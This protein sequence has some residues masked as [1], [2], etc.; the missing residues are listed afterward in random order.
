[1]RKLL[2]SFIALFVMQSAMAQFIYKIKADSVLITNDSCTAELNLENSTKNVPGSFLY[3]KGKGRTEFRKVMTKINDSIYLIGND[4]LKTG[5]GSSNLSFLDGLIRSGNAVYLGNTISGSGTHNFTTNRYQYLNGNFYSIGGTKYDPVTRPVFRFYDNGDFTSKAQNNLTG[6]TFTSESNG[7]RYTAKYGIFEVGTANNFDTSISTVCCGSLSKSAIV[8]NSDFLNTF[9]GDIHGS[10]IGG[11]AMNLQ[12]VAWSSVFGE[13]HGA[14]GSGFIN[15]SIIGGYGHNFTEE[16][17]GSVLGG[18]A[19]QIVKPMSDMI[20]GG[21]VNTAADTSNFS[22]IGGIVNQ[23]GGSGQLVSGSRLINKTP[24]GTTVG[25]SN[26]DFISLPYTGRL[27]YT[28][29]TLTGIPNLDKY[30]IFAI[31]N[32][33]NYNSPTTRSNAMT[34]LYNGRTQ[35]NTTGFSNTLT[36]TDVTPKAAFE[37]VSTNSGVLLPKLTTVQRDAIITADKQNGLLLYNTDNSKFQFYNGSAWKTICDSCTTG[38]GSGTAWSLTGNAGISY[39]ANFLGTTDNTTLGFRA[40]NI[41]RGSLSAAGNWTFSSPDISGSGFLVNNAY[42]SFVSSRP[43]NANNGPTVTIQSDVE[44]EAYGQLMLAGTSGNSAVK[45]FKLGVN[46]TGSYGFLNLID[47]NSGLG[48]PLVLQNHGGN[49]GIGTGVSV[50]PAYKLD[51]AGTAR[52]QTLPFIASRDTVVT[53]DPVTKQ[54]A[55]TKITA[56]G[57]GSAWL[58]TG[59]AGTVA[60]TNFVGTTDNIDLRFRTNNTEKVTITSGGIVGIGIMTPA[61]GGGVKLHVPGNITS[62]GL[63]SGSEKFGFGAVADSIYATAIGNSSNAKFQATAVGSN[64]LATGNY[65]VAIGREATASGGFDV[66]LGRAA[67][68]SGIYSTAIGYSSAVTHQGSIVIGA[69]TSS[70]T[71]NQFI[72]GS[73]IPG[74]D[75]REVIFGMGDASPNAITYGGV[76][77]RATNGSGTDNIGANLRIAAGRGTGAGVGGIISFFTTPSG[78]AGTTLNTENEVM[79]LNQ[80]GNV[81]IGTTNPVYRLDVNG[82]ARIQTLPFIAS[83]DTVVTY[84]PVSKQLAVTKITAGGG[85]TTVK[86]TAD[87]TAQTTTT[88]ADATGLSFAAA[89]NTYYHFKFVVVFRTAATTTGIQLSVAAP[90]TPT[91]FSAKASIA[92]A[93]DGASG[94]WQGWITASND[95]VIG[96]GVQAANTDYV[97]IV[98]GTIR[99]GATAGTVQLRYASEVA[100]SAVTIRNGSLA[101][102]TTY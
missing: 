47:Q 61:T 96:T 55:A 75:T 46:T 91:V 4:T 3:N 45:R 19:N 16:I 6:N 53:Y 64:A 102:I 7:I 76:K 5:A 66:A 69:N 81:G 24:F 92:I 79:R 95:A 74:Y 49:V 83:R 18:N 70:T 32:N 29:S 22:I 44:N 11:D 65:S 57:G 54:L 90:A 67:T 71:N 85:P 50:M 21:F 42:S 62:P 51:V 86:L 41:E 58:L 37:V 63:Q 2:F 77:I 59:N 82:T 40:N 80:L 30:P 23:Y 13:G 14:S 94:E 101:I 84:D 73:S 68:V 88:L 56:G 12:G 10:I 89:A 34:V 78:A 93:A 43:S 33:R 9:R 35:I 27:A 36:E 8:I 98:E 20:I 48:M 25:N 72:V 28:G 1:M 38:G 97:A 99:T 60:A 52:I 17:S 31:G 26:V 100:A 15:K 87:L 39:P